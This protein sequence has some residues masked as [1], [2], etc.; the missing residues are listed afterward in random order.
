MIAG[1]TQSAN[2]SDNAG[3]DNFK[4]LLSSASATIG[5]SNGEQDNAA[6]KNDLSQAENERLAKERET[7]IAEL[8][9]EIN[10]MSDDYSAISSAKSA[11]EA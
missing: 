10:R 3:F 5:Q 4:M 2:Q 6:E 8:K 1:Q 9:E 7:Q 11:L